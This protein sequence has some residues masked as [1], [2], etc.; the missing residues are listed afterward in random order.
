MGFPLKGGPL[1][2]LRP[3]VLSLAPTMFISV[4]SPTVNGEVEPV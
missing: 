3:S 1:R 2:G 4:V